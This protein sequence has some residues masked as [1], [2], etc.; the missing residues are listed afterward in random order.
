[1]VICILPKYLFI[2]KVAICNFL[3]IFLS[4]YTLFMQN[5]IVFFSILLFSL[6]CSNKKS[7]TFATQQENK[8]KVIGYYASWS[9]Q[10]DSLNFDGLTHIN[11]SFAI[12]AKTCNVLQPI[13]EVGKLSRLVEL[14]HQKGKKIFLA[15]GGWDIEDGGGNDQRFHKIAENAQNR[16]I[17]VKNIMD[18]VEKYNLDGIDMDWEYPDADSPS[19]EHYVALMHELAGELHSQKK[20]LSAAVVS[21]GEKGF[22]IKKGVFNDVDWL[23]IMAYDNDNGIATKPHSPYELAEKS[24]DYWLN[25]RK[26]PAEKAILGLPFYGKPYQKNQSTDYKDLLAA[27]AKP[28]EDSFKNILYNGTETIKKKVQLAQ[29]LN[30]GG[31][32]IWEITADS[33]D[34]NS[35]VKAINSAMK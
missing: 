19:V 20:Q 29:K 18:F 23:N 4:K 13:E 21:L 31:V 34:G 15:I 2:K 22:G 5:S 6:T 7:Q 30:C 33:K 26:L 32:M 10:P 11:F 12:P 24:L 28:N 1:M 17:F 8:M 35:L 16:S 3:A 14:G 25:E 9:G 27:G